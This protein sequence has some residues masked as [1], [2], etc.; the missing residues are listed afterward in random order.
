MKGLIFSIVV[1]FSGCSVLPSIPVPQSHVPTTNW[2]I[3]PAMSD[4]FTNTVL[5][6]VKWEIRTNAMKDANP[7]VCCIYT[8]TYTLTNG[9]LVLTPEPAATADWWN[10]WYGPGLFMMPLAWGTGDFKIEAQVEYT[11][12]GV[13]SSHFAGVIVQ[14][15]SNPYHYIKFVSFGSL[16]HLFDMNICRDKNGWPFSGFIHYLNPTTN[17]S[18][19]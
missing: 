1:L 16:P 17:L 12:A 14:D 7:P 15:T 18:L 4:S 6:P 13:S 3:L 19:T 2:D 9:E 5:D 10:G 8:L 11:P